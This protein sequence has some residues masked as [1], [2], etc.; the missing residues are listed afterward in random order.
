MAFGPWFY[1]RLFQSLD[2]CYPLSYRPPL[3]YLFCTDDISSAQW[4]IC[5]PSLQLLPLCR[6]G[7]RKGRC[8][9]GNHALRK[10]SRCQDIIVL[11]SWEQY[12]YS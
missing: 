11:L 8:A 10:R 12:L 6:E 1:S 7:A 5:V 2:R 9:D 4:T 3:L